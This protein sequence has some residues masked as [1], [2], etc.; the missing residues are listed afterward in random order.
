M[1]AFLKTTDD[2]GN[3]KIG[4]AP[5]TGALNFKNMV[6][7]L[8]QIMQHE[9]RELKGNKESEQNNDEETLSS[10]TTINEFKNY[11]LINE[12]CRNKTCVLAFDKP[13]FNRNNQI[14]INIEELKQVQ[15][16]YNKESLEIFVIDGGCFFDLLADLG[17]NW[18]NIPWLV[19]YDGKNKSIYPLQERFTAQGIRTN[20]I[21]IRKNIIK[22]IGTLDKL[23]FGDRDC[24][25][26]NFKVRK[27]FDK[28]KNPENDELVYQIVEESKKK[29]ENILPEKSKKE[30]RRERRL[31][32]EKRR[33]EGKN[34]EF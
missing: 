14:N 26:E 1:L 6:D 29:E 20:L 28:Y 23:A 34:E 5:F 11:S 2:E 16:F 12:K 25:A 3:G 30:L 10:D 15:G 9:K 31:E 21:K 4:A 32:R 17:M 24:E 22:K 18:E 8:L 13:Y 7:F 33:K 19:I 27:I